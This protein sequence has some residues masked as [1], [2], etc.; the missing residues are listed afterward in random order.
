MILNAEFTHMPVVTLKLKSVPNKEVALSGTLRIK[1][2]FK[3]FS[4]F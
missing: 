3:T 1:K 2:V 4:D